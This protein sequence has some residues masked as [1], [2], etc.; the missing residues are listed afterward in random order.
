LARQLPEPAAINSRY[1]LYRLQNL[2][3]LLSIAEPAPTSTFVDV[4]PD[5]WAYEPIEALYEAGYIAGCSTSPL[6]YCPERIL[7]RAES[8][9]FILR[10]NYGSIQN[11]PHT[12]PVSPTFAD[13]DPG[14]WG[15]GWIES[16]WTDGFTAGCSADPL[17]YCPLQEN[18]RAEGSV[19]FLRIK[20]GADFQPTPAAGLFSDVESGAWY[21]DW[22]EVAY[23]DGL[24][25]ACGTD[26]LRICPEIPLDRAWAADI[27]VKAK[28]L[29]A[30]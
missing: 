26:P 17:A 28:G 21:A 6:M 27:M 25:L 14:Y 19:F 30:P 11:P 10:G 18:T 20:Y 9:V 3:T 23:L 16:L 8:S 2:V 24:L 13:V 1:D 12:P 29:S 22:I 5:H 15:Y 7:T 4:P